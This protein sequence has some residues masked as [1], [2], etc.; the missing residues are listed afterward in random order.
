MV[1]EIIDLHEYF[2]TCPECKEATWYI[3]WNRECTEVMQI[4]CA[5]CGYILENPM[6]NTQPYEFEIDEFDEITDIDFESDYES[7]TEAE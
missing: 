3:Q 6:F 7:E 2:T 1:A 5:E 4:I